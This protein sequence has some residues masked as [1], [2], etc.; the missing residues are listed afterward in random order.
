MKTTLL[1]SVLLLLLLLGGRQD[2][3]SYERLERGGPGLASED[4]RRNDNDNSNGC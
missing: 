4:R 3:G 2:L 1:L